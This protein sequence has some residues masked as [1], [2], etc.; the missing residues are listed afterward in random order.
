M[1]Q[2]IY[3][4]HLEQFCRKT[5]LH[6]LLKFSYDLLTDPITTV[7]SKFLIQRRR[8]TIDGISAEFV[9]STNREYRRIRAI[10]HDGEEIRS[11]LEHLRPSD[12][13]WDIG[14]NVGTHT[15]FPAQMLTEGFVVSFEPYPPNVQQLRANLTVNNLKNVHIEQVALGETK[16]ESQLRIEGSEAGYG[17][18][19]LNEKT[20][21]N[22]IAVEVV[23]G[24]VFVQKYGFPTVLKIDVQG[25][26]M[27][28]LRGLEHVLD[29]KCRLIFCEVH[30]SRDVSVS[31]V[32]NYL[33][34]WGFTLEKQGS[35]GTVRITATRN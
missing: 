18:H 21:T 23:P 3:N 33:T 7:L 11:I 2:E 16:D 13:L 24:D 34:D 9:V 20:S 31:D 14:A 35:G 29:G 25:A 17:S 12:L 30:E 27:Q 5:G 28:V 6:P 4:E 26:E 22:S 8:V 32:E 15:I 19:S 10:E 1:I